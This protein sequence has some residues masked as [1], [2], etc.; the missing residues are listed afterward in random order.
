MKDRIKIRNDG[1]IIIN[2]IRSDIV[3]FDVTRSFDNYSIRFQSLKA[4]G[5]VRKEYAK[6][7]ERFATSLDKPKELKKLWDD[8]KKQ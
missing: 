8:Y 4:Y 6:W 3:G 7:L 1:I 5:N 2:G